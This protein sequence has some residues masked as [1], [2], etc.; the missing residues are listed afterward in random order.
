[1]IKRSI[2]VLVSAASLALAAAVVMN[3]SAV[4]QGRL[5]GANLLV[6]EQSA[7]NLERALSNFGAELPDAATRL[8][9]AANLATDLHQ[10]VAAKTFAQSARVMPPVARARLDALETKLRE[11]VAE[12]RASEHNADAVA[13]VSETGEVLISDST[14]L[15]VGTRVALTATAAGPAT[16]AAPAEGGGDT[17]DNKPKPAEEGAAPAAAGAEPA[18]GAATAIAQVTAAFDKKTSRGVIVR[19][20]VIRAVAAVPIVL[21]NKVTG[22]VVLE[23]RLGALPPP[24]MGDAFVLSGGRVILGTIPDSFKPPSTLPDHPFVLV[25][26]PEVRLSFFD[27]A[28]TQALVATAGPAGDVSA[29]VW[30]ARFHIPETEGVNGL[31][32]ADLSSSY[33]EAANNQDFIVGLIAAIWALNAAML[34]TAGL[35]TSVGI[36]KVTKALGDAQ[37]AAADEP[38]QIPTRRLPREVRRLVEALNPIIAVA[39]PGRVAPTMRLDL[40]PRL[41]PIEPTRVVDPSEQP[42]PKRSQPEAPSAEATATAVAQNAAPA[43]EAAKA[44]TPTPAP[45]AAAAKP[46]ATTASSN[47]GQEPTKPR[48]FTFPADAFSPAPSAPAPAPEPEAAELTTVM[49]AGGMDWAA[50]MAPKTEKP[51]SQPVPLAAPRPPALPTRAPA[52]PAASETPANA[53][54]ASAAASPAAA[55]APARAS[56]AP[57]APASAPAPSESDRHFREVYE[58]FLRAREASGEAGSLPFDKFRSRLEESRTTVVARHHC[59]DVRFQVYVKNG[60]AA[61]KATP[62]P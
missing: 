39:K 46:A 15:P 47:F 42:S 9:N 3:R 44:P 24:V 40:P 28:L 11:R 30:A 13:V 1:M 8:A 49:P 7:H 43:P 48:L 38:V 51:A 56:T 62:I 35:W 55:T 21:K 58:E 19:D 10:F 34:F 6:L 26:K 22:V 4:H 18:H 27:A 41:V 17:A 20:D 61:I 50:A 59:N 23:H 57:Q 45:T 5:L 2:L 54:P 12:F 29:G 25:A 53:A 32:T 37:D 33:A 31:V 52:A 16:A 36:K 60:K 14:L